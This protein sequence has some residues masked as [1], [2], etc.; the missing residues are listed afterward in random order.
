M[1]K[2]GSQ[3]RAALLLAA[4]SSEQGIGRRG[5]NWKLLTR[6]QAATSS[7]SRWFLCRGA[8]RGAGNHHVH[9]Y[10][11]FCRSISRLLFDTWVQ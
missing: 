9:L 6:G 10:A 3:S 7:K 4:Q 1:R 2:V 5:F 8:G 11:T